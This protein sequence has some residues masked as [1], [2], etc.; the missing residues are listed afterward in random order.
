VFPILE[1]LHNSQLH[2]GRHS[3][4]DDLLVSGK[5]LL[6]LRLVLD[7]RKVHFGSWLA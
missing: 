6:P 7:A 1:F 3:G 4:E 2:L 5:R